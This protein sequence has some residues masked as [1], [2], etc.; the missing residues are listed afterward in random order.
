MTNDTQ[1]LTEVMNNLKNELADDYS[2]F[3][4][5]DKVSL[6]VGLAFALVGVVLFIII[7]APVGLL[8]CSGSELFTCPN[9]SVEYV[10]WGDKV[11]FGAIP[12]LLGFGLIRRP[13]EKARQRFYP[14][15]AEQSQL[16][17]FDD[18]FKV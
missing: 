11:L 7:P 6:Y 17:W 3:S 1:T 4:G 15:D 5:L 13:I 2:Y 12:S 16:W 9:G 10:M 8:D 18:A 14:E